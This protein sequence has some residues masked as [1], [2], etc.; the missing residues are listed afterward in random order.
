MPDGICPILFSLGKELI[1]VTKNFD[2]IAGRPCSAKELSVAKDELQA[3]QAAIGKHR[4]EC[5]KCN[6]RQSERSALSLS[7]SSEELASQ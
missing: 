2:E 5:S 4:S 3:V 7:K 6:R 1:S